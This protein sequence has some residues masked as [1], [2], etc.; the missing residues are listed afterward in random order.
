[1]CRDFKEHDLESGNGN[2][3]DSWIY[4]LLRYWKNLQIIILLTKLEYKH[5][6]KS[7]Y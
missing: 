4:C 7:I 6:S 5:H 3:Y 2:N 1:M